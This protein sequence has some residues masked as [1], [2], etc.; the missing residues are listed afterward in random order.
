MNFATLNKLKSAPKVEPKKKEFDVKE[1]LDHR[2][3]MTYQV[4]SYFINEP[5][6]LLD[7]AERFDNSNDFII[8]DLDDSLLSIIEKHC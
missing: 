7:A 3:K 6:P 2:S 5:I 8:I 4:D 1:Y